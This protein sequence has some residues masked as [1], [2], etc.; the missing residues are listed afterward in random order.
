MIEPIN[1][2]KFKAFQ[3]VALYFFDTVDFLNANLQ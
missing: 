2:E 3:M 1:D